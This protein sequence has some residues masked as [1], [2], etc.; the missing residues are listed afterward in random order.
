M[1][2]LSLLVICF[3]GVHA[4]TVEE[5]SEDVCCEGQVSEPW[6]NG[7]MIAWGLRMRADLGNWTL[8]ENPL[9][10]GMRDGPDGW[11]PGEDPLGIG[12]RDGPDGWN[13]GDDTE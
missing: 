9:G 7:L 10:I 13:P 8:G 3:S 12:M 5:P 2:A 11:N 4:E 1:V 6:M